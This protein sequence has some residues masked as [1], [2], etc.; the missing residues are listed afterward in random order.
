MNGERSYTTKTW[1]Q[2]S[3]IESWS[4]DGSFTSM[5]LRGGP[6][7]SNWKRPCFQRQNGSEFPELAAQNFRNPQL[8]SCTEL[9]FEA[10][11]H[12]FVH[13]P[14]QDQSQEIWKCGK[15]NNVQMSGRS[16]AW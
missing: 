2:P 1:P 3:W 12:S 6:A 7:I 10:I 13:S 8:G 5:G 4:V 15:M 14:K 16:A 11:W 9:N